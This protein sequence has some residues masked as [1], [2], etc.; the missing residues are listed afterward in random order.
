MQA[1]RDYARQVNEVRELQRRF[2]AG[3]RSV[4]A[5]A[6]AAERALDKATTRILD[7]RPSLFGDDDAETG[8]AGRN[9]GLNVL[10]KSAGDGLPGWPRVILATDEDVA[11]VF[12]SRVG[13]WI[14]VA[15]LEN[16]AGA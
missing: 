12:A 6:K 3:D 8:A 15:I 14:E 9:V 11:R 7:E 10:V 4:V 5:E 16:K 1:I 13:E 2:F